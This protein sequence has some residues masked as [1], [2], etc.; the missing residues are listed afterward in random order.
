MTSLVLLGREQAVRQPGPAAVARKLDSVTAAA[1]PALMQDPD[2][3]LGPLGNCRAARHI[4]I[5]RNT[6]AT[7]H[8]VK[9]PASLSGPERTVLHQ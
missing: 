4:G 5:L 3:K 9:G 8:L 2:G 1:A 7:P 6:L